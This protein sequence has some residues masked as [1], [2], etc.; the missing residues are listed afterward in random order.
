MTDKHDDFRPIEWLPNGKVRFLDQT[1]L[2]AD[3]AWIETDDYRVVADAIRRLQLRGAPLIGISAAYALALAARSID[4]ADVSAFQNRLLRAAKELTATRPTAINLQW[5]VDRVLRL[6]ENLNDINEMREA[7]VADAK[8]IHAEDVQ[9]NQTMAEHGAALLEPNGA[10]LTHCN[11]GA[12]ATGGYG[13]ALGVL[14]KGREQGTVTQVYA[15]ETRP[16][17]QGARLT[18]WELQRAGIPATLITDTAAGS[19]MKRGLVSEVVVGADRIVANGDVANKIGTYQL[20]VLAHENSI[21]FYVAAPTS[22]IDVSTPSGEAIPIE[23]RSPEEVTGI[24]GVA[25]APAGTEAANPAF[26]VT[27]ARYVAAIITEQGVARAP[28]GES[29]PALFRDKVETRG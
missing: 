25:T 19:V 7:I 9:A 8:R 15:T 26:D 10:A 2:P 16:L 20:A 29:I 5:A 17:L 27:P 3:E 24:K 23:E 28:Y 12:L 1:L 13:T 6:V 21:P 14:R 4:E 11:A 22:T 18:V